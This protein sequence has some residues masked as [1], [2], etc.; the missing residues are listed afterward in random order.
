M[1][2]LAVSIHE[3]VAGPEQATLERLALEWCTHAAR[4]DRQAYGVAHVLEVQLR[5]RARARRR[6]APPAPASAPQRWWQWWRT[7]R[8]AGSGASL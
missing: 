6:Q 1:S 3:E 2:K 4:G 8:D 7:R 5:Q